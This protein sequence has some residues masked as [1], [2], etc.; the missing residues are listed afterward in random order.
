MTDVLESAIHDLI[1]DPQAYWPDDSYFHR[2]NRQK[3][4]RA[5]GALT[6]LHDVSRA[7]WFPVE[8]AKRRRKARQAHAWSP[9]ATP[10]R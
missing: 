2:R 1:Y 9:P 7:H 10:R 3:L 4:A 6:P 5:W 8:R